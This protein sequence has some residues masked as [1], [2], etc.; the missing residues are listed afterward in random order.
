[1]L[2]YR[3]I[4]CMTFWLTLIIS[5][6]TANANTRMRSWRALKAAGAAVL[7]DG[8][9]LLPEQPACRA[10]LEA[11]AAEVRGAGGSAHVL[12]VEEAP[13]AD[14]KALFDRSAD[15]AALLAPIRA[16]RAAVSHETALDLAKQARKLRRAFASLV[17]LDF[18][19]SEAAKQTEAA[20][21]ELEQAVLRILSPE[22]PRPVQA[23]IA[24]LDRKAFQGKTWATRQRPWV[25]RLACAWL[26]RSFID[27]KAKILWLESA[28]KCPKSAIGFDFD[29]AR[30]SHVGARVSFE[31]LLAS[32]E[33][34][35]PALSRLGHLVHF[36]DVG[37]LQPPE[38]CGIESV[39]A[40]M[41][42]SIESDD[43]LLQAASAVFD[44]L[45]QNF[46]REVTH[47]GEQ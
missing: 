27:R 34:E 7:R 41:R 23:D 17:E 30:F 16:A 42:D 39:L 46:S 38:A 3:Y 1:M 12:R 32:F 20:L 6:P 36:L 25:D 13:G 4:R 15:F 22:E 31:V 11:V 24:R 8:V 35:S 29:G 2:Q 44:G 37:G 47:H 19:A 26:I 18:F 14:F 21:Q 10:A 28:A 43:L 5:L 33:L 45:W 9:Y 40:G